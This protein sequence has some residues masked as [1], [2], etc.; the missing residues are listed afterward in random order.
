[1]SAIMDVVPDCRAGSNGDG[2]GRTCGSFSSGPL[3]RL[4]RPGTTPVGY[5]RS[6]CSEGRRGLDTA[7]EGAPDISRADAHQQG[8]DN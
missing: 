1:M 7:P 3:F 4:E 6:V 8:I 2:N 5:E